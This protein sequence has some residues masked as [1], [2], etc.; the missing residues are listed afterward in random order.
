MIRS[1]TAPSAVAPVVAYQLEAANR[2]LF[3]AHGS[4]PKVIDCTGQPAWLPPSG[5]NAIFTFISA[6]WKAPAEPPPGWPFDVRWIQLAS[7]GADAVPRWAYQG[8]TV[9][10]SRGITA[11]PI[12]EYVINVVID[13]EKRLS[14]VRVASRAEAL[15]LRDE[16][17]WRAMALGGVKGKT[18]G[19]VGLGAISREVAIR[20]H[21]FGMKVTAIRRSNTPSSL[22]FV[23]MRRDIHALVA[24]CDHLVLCAP[25]TA[26]TTGL[27]NDAVLGGAKPGMHLVNVSRGKLV[28]HAAL[29]RALTS[30]KVGYA[31]LDVTE[32]EPLPDGHEFYHHPNVRLTPHVAWYSPNHHER[33]TGQ[34]IQNLDRFARGEPLD[35]VVDPNTGY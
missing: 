18:L 23:E 19:L 21:A 31:T 1:T 30:G 20:A 15:R 32:P 4:R 12:A 3:A 8:V 14:E 6:W 22:D 29:S 27:I 7:A 34:I 2:A 26:Q 33:L 5:A 16:E 35:N 24:D 10:C 28:D 13:R 9:T 11:A 25:A 17:L